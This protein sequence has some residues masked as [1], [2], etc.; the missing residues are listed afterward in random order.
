ME[1]LIDLTRIHNAK[2]FHQALAQALD[3]P[4]WYGRNL[5]ALYDCLTEL[6]T[7][8]HLVLKNWDAAADFSEGF[9]GVFNDAQ[10]DN[11]DFT[12]QYV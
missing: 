4:H 9:E 3:F 6:E 7:P 1:H 8:V 10:T 5:D 2:E 12:I 11:P